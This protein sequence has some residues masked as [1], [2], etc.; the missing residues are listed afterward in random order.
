MEKDSERRFWIFFCAVRPAGREAGR[1]K[2]ALSLPGSCKK[3]SLSFSEKM[4]GSGL[5]N[6]Q[7]K[8]IINLINIF[9]KVVNKKERSCH[10]RENESG[11]HGRNWQDGL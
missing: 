4:R 6:G 9:N 10:G 8:I 1:E 7:Q 11:C 5:T 3:G 2:E